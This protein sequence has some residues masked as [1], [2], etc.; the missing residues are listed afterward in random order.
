MK[1]IISILIVCAMIATLALSLVSCTGNGEEETTHN[2]IIE[3]PN[4][5]DDENETVKQPENDD[6]DEDWELG[7]VPLN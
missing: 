3:S 2:I 5:E 4:E 7:G 6:D 1:K